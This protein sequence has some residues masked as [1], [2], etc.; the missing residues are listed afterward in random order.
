MTDTGAGMDEATQAHISTCSL[1]KGEG[2]ETGL[3][4]ATVYGIVRQHNG[5]ITAHSEIGVGTIF[6]VYLPVSEQF[7]FPAPEKATVVR[8]GVETILLAEDEENVR[9]LAQR[10][11]ENAGYT[12]FAAVNG[13][14]ALRLFEKHSDVIQLLLLDVVMPGL[15]GRAVS[16]AH[17]RHPPRDPRAVCKRL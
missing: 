9:K 7:G 12:V 4:L 11:L 14:E 8:G 2:R 1:T 6:R 10:V 3:G 13:E 16:R 15:G 17:P 5:M